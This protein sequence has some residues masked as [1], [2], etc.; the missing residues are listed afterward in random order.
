MLANN[1]GR[2]KEGVHSSCV[3]TYLRT[4]SLVSRPCRWMGALVSSLNEP[5]KGDRSRLCWGGK[6]GAHA[7]EYLLFL[8]F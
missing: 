6:E 5:L 8:S 7:A 4:A 3:C 2:T 1:E